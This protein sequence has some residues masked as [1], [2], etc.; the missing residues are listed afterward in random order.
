VLQLR[1]RRAGSF[2]RWPGILDLIGLRP[3]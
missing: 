1:E 2:F 3:P